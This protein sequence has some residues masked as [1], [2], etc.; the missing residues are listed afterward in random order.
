VTT[1]GE[2][3][4]PAE[5]HVATTIDALRQATK[6]TTE[7]QERLVLLLW[8][9]G[10]P[11]AMEDTCIHRQRSL[12]EGV[13]LNG[14]IV[15]PGHQ[16]AFDLETGLCKVRDRYQPLHAV[17]VDG[18]HVLVALCEPRADGLDRVPAAPDETAADS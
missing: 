11:V 12:S 10:R 16:W 4:A 2:A 1:V 15:C 17:R 14:R 5:W 6:L 9:D 7:V 3:E 13:L 18:E 8:N